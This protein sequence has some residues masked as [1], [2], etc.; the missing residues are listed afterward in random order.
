MELDQYTNKKIISKF[1]L[2]ES[3][4]NTNEKYHFKI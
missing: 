2:I 1:T 4:Q 3:D